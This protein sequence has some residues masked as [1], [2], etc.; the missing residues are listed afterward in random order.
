MGMIICEDHGRTGIRTGILE[1]ICQKVLDDTP[2]SQ[3]ELSY[4]LVDYYDNKK[5]MFSNR[6]IVT[7]KFKEE[8]KLNDYYKVTTEEEDR[9]LYKKLG[10]NIGVLCG[11]CFDEYLKKYNIIIDSEG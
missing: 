6:Y 2:I 10:S 8:S 9:L 7:K 3:E 4:I 1:Q 11:K 5:F